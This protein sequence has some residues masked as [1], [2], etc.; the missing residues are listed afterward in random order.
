MLRLAS[1][2]DADTTNNS[3][4]GAMIH[5]ANPSVP[6]SYKL[7]TT[8][9]EAHTFCWTIKVAWNLGKREDC[10]ALFVLHNA[11]WTQIAAD[12]VKAATTM[13]III[14]DEVL[15]LRGFKFRLAVSEYTLR[16][17]LVLQDNHDEENFST[18]EEQASS[19]RKMMTRQSTGRSQRRNDDEEAGDKSPE[20]QNFHFGATAKW[21]N[22][23]TFRASCLL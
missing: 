12:L 17:L 16:C 13:S 7:N 18:I 2:A 11:D 20:D 4:G 5:G 21:M 8:V 9:I 3:P 1:A 19:L 10:A 15:G 23:K 6:S 22:E 14:E